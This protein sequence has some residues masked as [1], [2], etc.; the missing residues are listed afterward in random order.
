MT[1]QYLYSYQRKSF[2]A[3]HHQGVLPEFGYKSVSVKGQ[4]WVGPRGA[5][6]QLGEL[7][8]D[9][10]IVAGHVTIEPSKQGLAYVKNKDS[11]F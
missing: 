6:W 10:W 5:I 8:V 7:L 4:R 9:I 3:C 1:D 2:G 11:Y